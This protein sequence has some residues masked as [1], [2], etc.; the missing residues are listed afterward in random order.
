VHEPTVPEQELFTLR[1]RIDSLD[2]KLVR[3]LAERFDLVASAAEYKS[4][5]RSLGDPERVEAVLARVRAH[6]ADCGAEPSAVDAVYRVLIDEGIQLEILAYDQRVGSDGMTGDRIRDAPKDLPMDG[7]VGAPTNLSMDCAA[8]VAT[9]ELMSIMST[10]RAMRRLDDRAVAPDLLDRLVQAAS[11]AP[12]GGNRQDYRFIVVSDREQ[13]A[14][15]APSWSKAMD[16]YLGAL[17]PGMSSAESERFE[18]V[19]AAMTYQCQ[20]FDRIPAL[21]VVCRE[22]VNFWRRLVPR[23]WKALRQLW[24]LR[25][26]ERLR[27]LGNLRRWA[28]RG[29]AASVYPAVQNL[30]LAARAHGLGATLTTWHSAFEQDFKAVL[31]VPR[32]VDI[33]AIVPVGYPLGRFGPVRRRPVTELVNRERWQVESC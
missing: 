20:H 18:R 22:P 24:T 33:Y 27:V 3:L 25:P 4:D 19:R 21:I 10:M 31:G 28:N 32:T 2:S 9:E 7:V 15:L 11:W 8:G 12:V 17:L 23:P 1:D 6:A 26:A 13:L 30:L 14:R 29:G 16:F 5:R